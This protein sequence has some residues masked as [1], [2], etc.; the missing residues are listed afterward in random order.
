MHIVT[1]PPAPPIQPPPLLSPRQQPIVCVRQRASVP[2]G[3]QI[4]HRACAHFSDH[5]GRA[6][7]IHFPACRPGCVAPVAMEANSQ[8]R[9]PLGVHSMDSL[10]Q[11]IHT[12]AWEQYRLMQPS[13]SAEHGGLADVRRDV[14]PPPLVPPPP[15]DRSHHRHR[16]GDLVRCD[17]LAR[18]RVKGQKKDNCIFMC[19]R[20]IPAPERCSSMTFNLPGGWMC[21]KKKKKFGNTML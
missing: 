19:R 9:K 11:N 15:Q 13:N 10:R 21:K 1:P 3:T 20:N 4:W 2:P 16:D 12:H 18:R 6:P 7:F 8:A 17:L 5:T 14:L